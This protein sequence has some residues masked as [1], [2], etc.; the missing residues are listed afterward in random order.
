MKLTLSILFMLF[1]LSFLTGC[2]DDDN[3][4]PNVTT[5][6]NIIETAE[7]AGSFSI[8]LTALET[9]DL[10][11][12]LEADGT[13]TVFAPTDAAFERYLSENNLTA[14]ALL[15]SDQLSDILTY[16]VLSTEVDSTAAI[17]VATSADNVV[18]ALNG[19]PFALSTVD[20]KLYI[21]QAMVSTPD[22]MASNG[23][24]HV[25]DQVLIPATDST[26]SDTT[27][28]IAELV[29]ELASSDPAEFSILLQAVQTAG[30]A[31]A[32]SDTN[33]TYTVFAPTDAA[34]TALLNEL[35]ITASDLLSSPDLAS[36]LTQHVIAGAEIDQIAA[37]AANGKTVQTLNNDSALSV[38]IMD[39]KLTIEDS[40]VVIANVKTANGIIHVI[41]TVIDTVD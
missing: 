30:L 39:G 24:I 35:G 19:S 18:D 5:E 13:Y 14:D 6:K 2:N 23:V 7:A 16:H 31:G 38:M 28:T 10:T 33:E 27:K 40:A 36:I 12:T 17:S 3:D 34:F 1:S 20:N 26:L 25:I 37:Y 8:L 15:A 4:S 21:N 11:D 22:V 32:L 29:I 41:D 9:A